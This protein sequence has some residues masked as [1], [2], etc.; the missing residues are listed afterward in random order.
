MGTEYRE[1]APKTVFTRFVSALEH[2]KTMRV[3]YSETL[4]HLVT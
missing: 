4:C 1:E 2:A 3:D